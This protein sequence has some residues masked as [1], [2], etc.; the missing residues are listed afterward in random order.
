MA[1]KPP[2]R[3]LASVPI[4][5]V[6]LLVLLLG[7]M[8]ALSTVI[9]VAGVDETTLALQ[10]KRRDLTVDELVVDRAGGWLAVYGCVRHDLAV[11]V[12]RA[13]GPFR[14]G[15][16]ELERGRRDNPDAPA[17]ADRVFTPLSALDD[18]DEESA[19]KKIFAL[20]ED[21]DTLGDTISFAYRS[22]V[23][24]PP[25][26]AIVTGVVGHGAGH[27][28]AAS[29]GSKFLTETLK[30]DL[31]GRPLLVKGKQPGVRWMAFMTLA[32]GAHGYLLCLLLVVW[33][34]RRTL[35]RRAILSGQVSEAEEDFFRSET[36]D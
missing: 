32:A 10:K 26:K 15:S 4:R 24:P 8:A 11:G 30:L 27:G 31:D 28:R 17:E 25:V 16:T 20:I 36:V 33:A 35:R 19:P 9:F 29:Q 5:L 2:T 12:N 13:R 22:K 6:L 14:L 3:Y 21:D 23:L 18:C 1:I 7:G 34:V